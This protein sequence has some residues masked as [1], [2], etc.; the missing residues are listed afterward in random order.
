MDW[1]MRTFRGT[2]LCA[3]AV[4]C[5]GWLVFWEPSRTWAQRESA[6][7]QVERVALMPFFRGVQTYSVQE[8]LNCAVC[9]LTQ[10]EDP[11]VPDA[12]RILT[13]LVQTRLE[14]RFGYA[15]V[16]Q[17]KVKG[18]YDA[19]PKDET[20]DTPLSLAQ[21]LGRALGASHM[22]VGN[23]WKFRERVGGSMGVESPASV[24]FLLHFVE[25]ATGTVLWKGT[26]NE[27]QRSLS[28]NILDAPAFFKR[29]A[30]WLTAEELARSGVDE[31]FRKMTF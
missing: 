23:V 4:A 13:E 1:T 14:K 10:E 9:R 8:S 16:P 26:F 12:D 3:V 24:A 6:P 2:I 22:M 29:G 15:A 20:Q 21:R 25:V 19:M 7:A 30:K 18:V 11:S 27:T 31:L 17:S 5:A 28:E